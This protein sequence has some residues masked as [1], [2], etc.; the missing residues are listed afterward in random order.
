MK[1]KKLVKHISCNRKS[2]FDSTTRNLNQK[3]N[4][5]KCQCE[6]KKYRTYKKY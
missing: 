2:K 6:Y 3:W 4:S 5:N 1:H